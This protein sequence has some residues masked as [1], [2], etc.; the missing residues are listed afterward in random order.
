MNS[1][2]KN[3]KTTTK[4]NFNLLGHNFHRYILNYQANIGF[5]QKGGAKHS[6]DNQEHLKRLVSDVN[7]LSPKENIQ[8]VFA[9]FLFGN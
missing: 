8:V 3:N 5:A 2:N 7:I 1:N 6:S 9:E 4:E